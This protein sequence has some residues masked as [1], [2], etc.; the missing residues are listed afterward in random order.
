MSWE[1][2]ARNILM[3]SG[4]NWNHFDNTEM[5][6]PSYTYIENNI[7]DDI[8]LF[9]RYNTIPYRTKIKIIKSMI[10]LYSEINLHTRVTWHEYNSNF[11]NIIRNSISVAFKIEARKIYLKKY[12]IK[13]RLTRF[14]RKWKEQYYAPPDENNPLGGKGYQK[15]LAEFS[16]FIDPLTSS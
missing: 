9:V 12:F 2:N 14:A 6:G 4:L 15:A 3:S 11:K 13:P 1:N 8:K 10:N 16:V 5:P 7:L